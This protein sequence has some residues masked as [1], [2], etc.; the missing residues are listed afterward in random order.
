ML[1]AFFAR[2][3]FESVRGE[4]VDPKEI[5]STYVKM[6]HYGAPTR[7]IDWTESFGTALFFA[8]ND[9]PDINGRLYISS[10]ECM[11]L[12]FASQVEKNGGFEKFIATLQ[13]ELYKNYRAKKPHEEIVEDNITVPEGKGYF[14]VVRNVKFTN[15]RILAQRGH[16]TFTIAPPGTTPKPDSVEYVEIT[17]EEKREIKDL[18][19]QMNVDEYTIYPDIIGLASYVKSAANLNPRKE[20]NSIDYFTYQ[21]SCQAEGFLLKRA[22]K[23][24]L[25]DIDTNLFR[26]THRSILSVAIYNKDF[27]KKTI[28]ENIKDEDLKKDV[29]EAFN[30]LG[31]TYLGNIIF[32]FHLKKRAESFV[33]EIL[34]QHLHS[35]SEDAG[36]LG[37]LEYHHSSGLGSFDRF[38]TGLSKI[39]RPNGTDNFFKQ[40][41]T[42][43]NPVDLVVK[44]V[45][46]DFTKTRF[47][48]HHNVCA[49]DKVSSDDKELQALFSSLDGVRKI[50]ILVVRLLKL[51][52]NDANLTIKYHPA[53]TG[54]PRMTYRA[55][56][57]SSDCIIFLTANKEIPRPFSTFGLYLE[58]KGNITRRLTEPSRQAEERQQFPAKGLINCI[59]RDKSS[60]LRGIGE[61]LATELRYKF[62]EE[63]P[64][65]F[66][67][68]EDVLAAIVNK[69]EI[70][71]D[72][73]ANHIL[74]IKQIV[75]E[76]LNH[77]KAFFQSE[78]ERRHAARHIQ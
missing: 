69:C 41:I 76:V 42:I 27:V 56:N 63:S 24:T 3:H 19:A 11:E 61:L 18:L 4:G 70:T 37:I 8:T 51:S 1:R 45:S 14:D 32:P 75:V 49:D 72:E 54:R 44:S 66:L 36:G 34:S 50:A 47:H 13:R 12:E 64:M 60:F 68:R 25:D 23:S 67:N 5:K 52:P 71:D 57:K 16:F 6:Q 77:A 48:G 17:K 73:A 9:N 29:L 58:G 15:P 7:L 30:E 38:A 46:K 53:S 78:I 31:E 40:V 22:N 21:N 55:S 39:T 59:H 43:N 20:F 10:P 26:D 33:C 65:A 35:C 62:G 28:E 2:E 74:E